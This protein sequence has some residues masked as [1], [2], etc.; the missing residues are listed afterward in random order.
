MSRRIRWTPLH[1]S[2]FPGAFPALARAN[3]VALGW[4]EPDGDHTSGTRKTP[5][6]YEENT[7]EIRR[8]HEDNTSATPKQPACK[9]L[10]ARSV[11]ACARLYFCD[12][13]K[14]EAGYPLASFLTGPE[15]TAA[16][17]VR[18]TSDGQLRASG[19]PHLQ[20]GFIK[21]LSQQRASDFGLNQCPNGGSRGF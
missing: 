11:P 18:D 2:S 4:P 6:E 5:R 7:N 14:P 16:R 21:V 1:C 17:R 20:Q 3:Q 19:S 9:G 8:E 13:R 15:T 12:P 10:V